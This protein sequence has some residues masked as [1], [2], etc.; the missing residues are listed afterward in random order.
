MRRVAGVLEGSYGLAGGE[1]STLTLRLSVA[2]S[3]IL[4]CFKS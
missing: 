1:D 2:K 4:K 3:S